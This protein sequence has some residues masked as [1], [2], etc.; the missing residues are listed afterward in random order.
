M[1][2]PLNDMRFYQLILQISLFIGFPSFVF[3]QTLDWGNSL[4]GSG[5]ERAWGLTIDSLGNTVSTGQYTDSVDADPGPGTFYL[6]SEGYSRS[7]IRKLTPDN[8]LVWAYNISS[9]SGTCTALASDAD[10]NTFAVG[11]F[12]A[13]PDFDHSQDSLVLSSNGLTDVF[14]LK[15]DPFGE[16]IWAKSFG[17]SMEENAYSVTVDQWGNCLV[18]GTFMDTVDFDPGI[19]VTEDYSNGS[20]DVFVLKLSP[21]GDF[22][23][24]KCIGGTLNDAARTI[25]TDL[26]GNVYSA[27]EFRGDV[28]LNPISGT[29]VHSVAESAD[30]YIQKLDSSGNYLWARFI[31]GDSYDVIQ[32]LT[33]DP[34]SSTVYATGSFESTVNFNPMGAAIFLTSMNGYPDCFVWKL[35]QNGTVVWA[36]QI[37]DEFHDNGNSIATDQTGYIYVGGNFTGTVDFD[38]G[39]GVHNITAL[40]NG[41]DS[42]IQKLNANG[43]FMWVETWGSG[44]SFDDMNGVKVS[45]MGDVYGLGLYGSSMDLDATSD[46]NYLVSN[47]NMDIFLVKLNQT[48]FG[49]DEKEQAV[50]T[51]DSNP[52]VE[53]FKI[54]FG[55]LMNQVD[56]SLIDS[57]GTV[58]QTESCKY[59]NDYQV[60]VPNLNRGIYF[61]HIQQNDSQQVIKLLKL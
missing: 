22:K 41:V 3:S 33:V 61:L 17:G 45:Q 39:A 27:G 32:S 9:N 10:G 50:F 52:F 6:F 59:C 51:V 4:G 26:N 31:G 24:V 29:L 34:V 1:N 16:L 43:E 7:Y 20:I 8:E 18:A 28:E 19:G 38:P 13:T 47:G 40:M 23:W 5:T 53:S 36:K 15:I 48:T 56:F 46:T 30:I 58:V 44:F 42:Y 37:G 55:S 60:D 57:K 11:V 21:S 35:Q 25:A 12:Q 49:I 14:V 54:H 2:Q